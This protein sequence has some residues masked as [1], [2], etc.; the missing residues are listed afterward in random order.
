[1]NTTIFLAQLW[2]PAIVA[3]GIGIFAS[4]SYYVKIYRELEK[5]ALA[6][7][8]FGLVAMTAGTAHILYH[9]LWGSFLEG[10]VSFLGWGLFLKGLLFVAAPKAVDKSGDWWVR[11]GLID[12]SGLLTLAAGAYLAWAAYF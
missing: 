11:R 10:L 12:F 4:R 6:V 9:N 7:L 3:V 5:D 2:A 8:L 1:M